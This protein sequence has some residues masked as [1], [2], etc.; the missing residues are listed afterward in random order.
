MADHL[1]KGQDM[2]HPLNYAPTLWDRSSTTEYVQHSYI[3]LS[4][5]S[6]RE[7]PGCVKFVQDVNTSSRRT[8]AKML[9]SEDLVRYYC[10]ACGRTVALPLIPRCSSGS[11]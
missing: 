5:Q 10:S 7:R 8:Y 2:I 1:F 3:R 11:R 6:L 9:E 4:S